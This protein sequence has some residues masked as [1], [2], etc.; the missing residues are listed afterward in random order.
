[1]ARQ[2]I[3]EGQIHPTTRIAAREE[4]VEESSNHIPLPNS[5]KSAGS[6]LVIYGYPRPKIANGRGAL[7]LY[8][9]PQMRENLWWFSYYIRIPPN[10]A[11]QAGVSR[12]NRG[13]LAKSAHA[14]NFGRGIRDI[15]R[16]LP[17]N[18]RCLESA[19][20]YPDIIWFHE[21][22][23]PRWDIAHLIISNP[24]WHSK[25]STI[26]YEGID[27]FEASILVISRMK[28][29]NFVVDLCTTCYRR[30][31]YN[32]DPHA[33]EVQFNGVEQVPTGTYA[34]ILRFPSDRRW[35]GKHKTSY[36]FTDFRFHAGFHADTHGSHHDIAEPSVDIQ[37]C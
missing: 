26:S 31:L 19:G 15:I 25:L 9:Y 7:L 34:M 22:L 14:R 3:E 13:T 12:Y 32:D 20:E 5:A 11:S 18:W 4:E 17:A 24:Q 27:Q 10:W 28:K 36:A 2:E 6:P 8:G 29:H 37:G 23:F 1:M 30:Q 21:E 35:S 33:I 16:G